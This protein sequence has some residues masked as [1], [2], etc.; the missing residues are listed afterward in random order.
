MKEYLNAGCAMPIPRNPAGIEKL[1]PRLNEQDLFERFMDEFGG[2]NSQE[3]TDVIGNQLLID[4]SL[5]ENSKGEWKIM[6][7]ERGPWLLYTAVNIKTP[8]EIWL[9]P[10]KLGGVDKLYYLSKFGT[11][12]NGLLSCI[13]VFSRD[14]KS[15]GIWT[16]RTN[17]ATMRED[18]YLESKRVIGDLKYWRWER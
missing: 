10:G 7:G 12:K 8:D 17:F 4:R 11:G 2:G 15:S 6:K 13:A 14:Q 1:S 18:G 5:F 16:G 3:F 9:E